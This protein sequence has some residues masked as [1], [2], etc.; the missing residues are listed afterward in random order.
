MA[1]LRKFVSY[2]RVDKKP[3]TRFSKYKKYSFVKAKPN[4]RIARFNSGDSKKNFDLVFHLE[5]KDILQIRDN[6]IESSRIACNRTMEK[7]LGKAGFYLTTRIY[8]HHILRENPLASGAG[9]DRLSTGMAH[10]FGKPIGI[11]ARV[12]KGQQILSLRTDKVNLQLAKRALKKASHKLP[13]KCT[14]KIEN[15]VQ[16]Q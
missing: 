14:I 15:F 3:Y 5:S 13:G 8:P 1:R 7:V 6:A 12:K 2:R 16:K 11:A 9:A 4:C 10:S